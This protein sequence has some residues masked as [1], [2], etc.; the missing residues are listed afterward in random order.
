MWNFE[1][2]SRLLQVWSPLLSIQDS[3]VIRS[4]LKFCGNC[5]N[6]FRSQGCSV[7]VGFNCELGDWN[8]TLISNRIRDFCV[9]HHFQAI[10]VAH[11]VSCLI[12]ARVSG[13]KLTNCVLLE[14]GLRLHGSL[15]PCFH[16]S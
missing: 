12:A 14:V 13:M 9:L 16:M 10:F 11:P 6:Y 3:W 7:S 1:V 2:A 15:P 4:N 8:F 5:C